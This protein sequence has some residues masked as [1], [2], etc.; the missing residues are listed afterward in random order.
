MRKREIGSRKAY[1]GAVLAAILCTV[2]ALGVWAGFG[3]RSGIFARG[4]GSV[5]GGWQDK[6]SDTVGLFYCHTKSL[7]KEEWAH[8][9]L[10]SAK[11]RSAR[12]EIKEL[13]DG[14]AFRFQP[15]GVSLVEL[16][17]WVESEARCCPFFDMAISVERD[18]GPMW[19]M[20]RG[21]DGV[22][23]FIRSEFKLDVR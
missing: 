23:Q 14:Y 20:L 2:V 5:V 21:K 8:K 18:G 12:V 4:L 10:I 15:G 13:A 11:L 6:N 3:Q 7:T 9:T 19:L 17:D 22:K 1:G 16:A